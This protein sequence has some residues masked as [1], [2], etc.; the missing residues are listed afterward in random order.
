MLLKY[1]YDT[2]LAQA[3]YMVGCQAKGEAVIVDPARDIEPYIEAAKTEGLEIVGALETHIHADY[4][5]GAREM[6]ERLNAKLYVSDEG[7]E[8]WK[9]EYVDG[10]PHQL[11]KNGDRFELGNLT[12]EVM[13]TPGHTPESIS[14]LLTDGGANANEPIG[15]FTGDFVFVG[16]IGR[17]D[18][19]EKAAGVEGTS[20]SGAYDMF[21]SLERFKQ[22]P[23][24]LQVW[25]AHGAGSACG[26]SLGAV[27]SSTVGYEKRFNWALKYNDKEQF[28]QDLIEGQPEPPV[29]FAVMKHV[30]KVG[31][32]LLSNLPEPEELKE[33]SEVETKITEGTQVIDTRDHQAFAQE[34]I[35]GSINIP[36]GGSFPNWAGWLVD[37]HRPLTLLISKDQSLN[38]IST[39]LQSVGIDTTDTVMEA[40]TALAQAEKTES[41]PEIHPEEAETKVKEGEVHVIDVRNLSEYNDGHISGSQHIMLGTLPNRMQ[42]VPDDKKIL[43]QCGSGLRS[44]IACSILQ[45]NGVKDVVNL[46]G[47][48]N[49]WINHQHIKTTSN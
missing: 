8:N 44:A 48:Y 29:Y 21:D 10:L 15:I 46:T 2:K 6:A 26:K 23:D 37:Y 42:E 5:S 25:P 38:E 27:P 33:V 39:A 11:V 9:Y 43:M 18:L 47:G 14:F 45:A 22:L 24:F 3:S 17:P 12:F 20:L 4:V 1:F 7:D 35:P 13:Y 41:Y 28:A 31:P 16:D 36:F 34:H 19:L 32:A 40:E 30:N 49:A